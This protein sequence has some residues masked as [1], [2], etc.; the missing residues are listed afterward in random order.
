MS[1][2]GYCWTKPAINSEAATTLCSKKLQRY[3]T[4]SII[5]KMKY[6]IRPNRHKFYNLGIAAWTSK[7]SSMP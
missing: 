3:S 5:M 2:F 4:L 7:S 1:V 6:L